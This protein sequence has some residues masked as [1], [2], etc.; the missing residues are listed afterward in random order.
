MIDVTES[1]DVRK[2]IDITLDQPVDLMVATKLFVNN[3]HLY[4]DGK[5]SERLSAAVDSHISTDIENLGNKPMNLLR[6]RKIRKKL[7]YFKF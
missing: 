7:G 2:A 1:R 6:K 3:F 4:R 5:S